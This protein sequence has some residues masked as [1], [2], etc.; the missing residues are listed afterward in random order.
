MIGY[1]EY[2]NT[3]PLPRRRAYFIFGDDDDAAD[4]FLLEGV[5]VKFDVSYNTGGM[6]A[7]AHFGIC[8]LNADHLKYLTSFFAFGNPRRNNRTIKFFAGYDDVRKPKKL[9]DIPLLY[10]GVVMLTSLTPPPDIWLNIEALACGN[11][12]SSKAQM[13]FKGEKTVREIAASA[14]QIYGLEL[15]WRAENL[16]DKKIKNFTVDGSGFEFARALHAVDGDLQFGSDSL[17]LR[18]TDTCPDFDNPALPS[19]KIDADHAMIGVP[20]FDYIG[21]KVDTLLNPLIRAGDYAVLKSRFQGGGD[22]RYFIRTV[23]HYGELRGND[24]NTSLDLMRPE[25]QGPPAEPELQDVGDL[26]N[27]PPIE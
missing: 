27:E 12:H 10:K 5:N 7:T 2:Q 8:N 20:R 18:V 9:K 14:A 15:E 11:I 25:T 3:A 23:R 16:G 26:D 24:F 21:A 13:S 17:R 6:F 22:D 19:W 4:K 1:N